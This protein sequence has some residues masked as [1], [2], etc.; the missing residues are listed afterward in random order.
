MKDKILVLDKMKWRDSP[1]IEGFVETCDHCFDPTIYIPNN[2]KQFKKLR[3]KFEWEQIM[4]CIIS[5]EYLHIVLTVLCD[6]KTSRELD[7]LFGQGV[8]H[9]NE[10]HGLCRLGYRMRDYGNG[11]V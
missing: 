8:N 2:P 1:E 7:N 9:K 5:H 10:Y 3:K 4:A 6:S 11:V